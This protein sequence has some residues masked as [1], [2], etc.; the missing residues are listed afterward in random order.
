MKLFAATSCALFSIFAVAAAL[1]AAPPPVTAKP[2][3][4]ATL[5]QSYSIRSRSLP[6]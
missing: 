2:V 3:A 5:H 1:G 6:T 4:L